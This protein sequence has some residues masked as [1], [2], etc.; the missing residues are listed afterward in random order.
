MEMKM[1]ARKAQQGFT[2][3]ELMIVVA[4]IGI[5]AAIAIPQYQDYVTRAR[6]STNYAS[7]Q[8]LKTAVAECMQN[9]AQAAIPAVA[10]C[11][12]TANMITAN[13]LPVGFTGVGQNATAV[14]WNGAAITITGAANAGSCV[15]TLTPSMGGG[16]S[17]VNWV[18]AS[19][20]AGCG[21]NRIGA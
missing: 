4:I 19:A 9:N 21:R 10:P 3:I 18:I 20:T 8:P 1:M 5:L 12:S 14:A 13:F 16:G 2:L 17:S 6:W 11:D 15:V 7:V